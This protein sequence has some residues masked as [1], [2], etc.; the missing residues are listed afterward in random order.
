ML[1]QQAWGHN[2]VTGHCLAMLSAPVPTLPW[3]QDAFAGLN[4]GSV[5]MQDIRRM[6]IGAVLASDISQH[7]T[8]TN[9]ACMHGPS[10]WGRAPPEDVLLLCKVVVHAADVSNP[11]RPFPIYAALAQRLHQELKCAEML[12]C[13]CLFHKGNPAALL[14]WQH[15]QWC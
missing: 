1:K 5:I 14:R 13:C 7:F 12:Q 11:A 3:T 8:L 2:D 4:G 9:Q 15:M 6:V 10:S